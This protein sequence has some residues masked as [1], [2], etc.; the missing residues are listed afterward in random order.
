M[1]LINCRMNDKQ[2]DYGCIKLSDVNGKH[3]G[4]PMDIAN[5]KYELGLS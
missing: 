5:A 1:K 3:I 2:P 4:N